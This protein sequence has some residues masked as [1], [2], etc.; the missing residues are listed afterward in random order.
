[1]GPRVSLSLLTVSAIM[2]WGMVALRGVSSVRLEVGGAAGW[3]LPSVR[4]VNYSDWA[5]THSFAIDDV[6]HFNYSREYHN[7]MIV[8]RAAYAACD[9]SSPISTFDDGSTLIQLDRPGSFYFLCGVPSHCQEG[10]KL[11]VK[12][13]R[14]SLSTSSSSSASSPQAS[15]SSSNNTDIITPSVGNNS[16]PSPIYPVESNDATASFISNPFYFTNIIHNTI[17]IIVII[18]VTVCT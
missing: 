2:V 5:A 18:I 15:N 16:S 14:H 7:V 3:T 8:T 9:S 6:L 12:V 1:M 10:Q 4:D 17:I 13:R 11:A